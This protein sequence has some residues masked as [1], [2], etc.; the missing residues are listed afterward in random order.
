HADAGV[1]MITFGLWQRKYGGGSNVLGSTLA[2][3]GRTYTIVGVTPPNMSIP[4][5]MPA[6]ANLHEATP[7]I[8]LPASLDSIGSGE[9]FAR[10]RP[11][12][13]AEAASRELQS[14]LA[15]LPVALQRQNGEFF[16]PVAAGP[17]HAR[18]LRARDFVDPREVTALDVLFVAVGVLLLIAC[19]NVAN[20]LMSRAWS[21][22]REFAVRV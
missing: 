12:V 4:M 18:A 7:S 22:R 8:W 5:T 11:G 13:S 17:S 14:I 9:V 19:A 20:L 16:R 15:S 3:D 6:R 1:A 21:R 10:L 2:I